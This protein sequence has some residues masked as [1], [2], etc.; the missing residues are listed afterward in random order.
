MLQDVTC[1]SK[2]ELINRQ[3]VHD[4][5]SST[6]QGSWFDTSL[7]VGAGRVI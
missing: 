7:D 1:K 4:M 2:K 6:F 3:E 5:M